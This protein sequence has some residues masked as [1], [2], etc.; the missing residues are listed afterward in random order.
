MVLE[1]SIND[2]NITE[3]IA[4]VER[5]L[6][7]EKQVSAE[8]R[9]LIQLLLTIVKL[10]VDKVGPNSRNSSKPPS[11]DPNRPRGRRRKVG[12]EKRK[13]GGQKGRQ[14]AYLKQVDS[15]D[16]VETLAIDRK[17]LPPGHYMHVRY[18]K[19]INIKGKLRW[20]HSASNEKWT[21]FF[22]H[23]RRGTEAMEAMGI[24]PHFKGISVHDHWKPYLRF[25]CE[26]AFCNAH[27]L[28]ELER[29][30]E[31]DGQRWALAMKRTP[32][33]PLSPRSP[34]QHTVMARAQRGE[35]LYRIGTTKASGLL[36]V[37]MKPQPA[38]APRSVGKRH[39]A[40]PLIPQGDR[41]PGLC[42]HGMGSP[43]G[44]LGRS[45][46][47]FCL[48]QIAFRFS[49]GIV[50]F[51]GTFHGEGQRVD[52][53]AAPH[54]RKPL[55]F[56]PERLGD[57]ELHLSHV[58]AQGTHPGPCGGHGQRKGDLTLDVPLFLRGGLRNP[59]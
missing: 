46:F 50:T 3:T 57:D 11:Q 36:V 16:V 8:L 32:G 13:P 40:P 52:D 26:H 18:E 4:N 53:R 27:H 45:L 58:S 37:Q 21:L 2:I 47:L 5:S 14:G 20:L 48:T 54:L 7:K 39:R 38:V 28:R 41:V 43:Q 29:A 1:V 51:E 44:R 49:D 34:M 56:L 31:Q 6:G 33:K 59:V 55:D 22:P 10:L 42:R 30:W 35:I 9:A 25:H 17:K 19:R 24:L 12:A 15:P 23:E